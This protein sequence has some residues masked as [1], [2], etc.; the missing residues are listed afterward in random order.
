MPR[1]DKRF[2]AVEMEPAIR[3]VEQHAAGCA[4]RDRCGFV[5]WRLP[6]CLRAAQLALG[7]GSRRLLRYSLIILRC[8]KIPLESE[9]HGLRLDTGAQTGVAPLL[10]EI[11]CGIPLFH[12][13]LTGTSLQLSLPVTHA[14]ALNR[15]PRNHYASSALFGRESRSH[16]V[17]FTKRAF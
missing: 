4:A 13:P 3:W 11:T 17:G 10:Q 6:S 7:I 1:R 12:Q 16:D 5:E 15:I 8:H 14:E 2:R 9:E